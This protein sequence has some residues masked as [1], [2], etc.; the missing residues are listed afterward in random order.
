MHCAILRRIIALLIPNT[1]ADFTPLA[2]MFGVDE[3]VTRENIDMWWR[4]FA[5]AACSWMV[6]VGQAL[7][8]WRRR[9]IRAGPA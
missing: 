4:G 5:L 1:H 6:V 7:L 8:R 2:A 3:L 9:N